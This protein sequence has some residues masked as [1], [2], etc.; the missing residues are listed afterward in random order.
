MLVGACLL[1]PLSFLARALFAQ[2]SDNSQTAPTIAQPIQLLD[3]IGMSTTIS[4]DGQ[5]VTVLFDNLIVE[6]SIVKRQPLVATRTETLRIPIKN[7]QDDVTV[8]HDVR[9]FLSADKARAALV[10]Q[11]CGKTT[12]VDLP[13]AVED[14]EDHPAKRK[15]KAP[16]SMSTADDFFVRIEGSLPA[17]AADHVTFF[18]L[19]EKDQDDPSQGAALFV[20]SVDV[21][22]NP[23]GSEEQ[24]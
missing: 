3:N 7:S 2:Q 1:V 17:G 16:E 21:S 19:T 5:A 12:V 22:I 9:G 6:T 23:A 10:I 18:L 14:A 11:A 8:I 24:E 4:P 20:D 13:K 15:R